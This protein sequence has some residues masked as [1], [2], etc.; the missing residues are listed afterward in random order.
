M[1]ST[2]EDASGALTNLKSNC[3]Y[4]I[5][6]GVTFLTLLVSAGVR[7]TPGVL[8][9]PLEQTFGWDRMAVTFPLASSL[10][11]LVQA[12]QRVN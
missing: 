6:A 12:E 4:R 2:K 8:I 9:I 11:C 5:I 3:I 1:N 10:D 7:S